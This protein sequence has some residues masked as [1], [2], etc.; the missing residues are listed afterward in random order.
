MLAMGGSLVFLT[1]SWNRRLTEGPG[2]GLLEQRDSSSPS[3]GVQNL[4]GG[5]LEGKEPA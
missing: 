1:C 2:D 3:D 4:L 5:S